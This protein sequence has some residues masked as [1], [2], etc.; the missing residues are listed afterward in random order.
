MTLT[1]T[2]ANGNSNQITKAAYVSVG[3]PNTITAAFTSDVQSG[4]APLTVRFTDQSTPGQ[5]P[6]TGWLWNFGDGETSTEQ[7]PTHVYA[8][9]G[10]YTVTLTVTSADGA[11]TMT[12]TRYITVVQGVPAAGALALALG[13]LLMA[14]FGGWLV[15]RRRIEA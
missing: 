6:I 5:S 10:E 7:N 9:P 15:C 11:D 2:D 4:S 1:V 8:E 3:A 13:A 12:R 14:A